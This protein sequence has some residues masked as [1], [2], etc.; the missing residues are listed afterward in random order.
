MVNTT[1]GQK[2]YQSGSQV[3][4]MVDISLIEVVMAVLILAAIVLVAMAYAL[5]KR[6]IQA[7]KVLVVGILACTGAVI[8][9]AIAL[10]AYIFL[11]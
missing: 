9:I 11:L 7:A 4:T 6:L 8:L 10:A 3:L 2:I 5:F 1:P